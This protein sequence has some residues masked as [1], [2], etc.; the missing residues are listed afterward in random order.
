MS[1]NR[2]QTGGWAR[3][4][5]SKRFMPSFHLPL[6]NTWFASPSHEY[7]YC[8]GRRQ[9]ALGSRRHP[10]DALAQWWRGIQSLNLLKMT[11]IGS[12]QWA[13]VLKGDLRVG[14]VTPEG[15]VYY[16][17]VVS[18]CAYPHPLS[19]KLQFRRQETCGISLR[20]T[21]IGLYS[22]FPGGNRLNYDSVSRPKIPHLTARSFCWSSIP[23]RSVKIPPSFL[24]SAIYATSV[25]LYLTII[26]RTGWPMCPRRLSL[27]T[28]K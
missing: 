26:N 21:P 27:R 11:L 15:Q 17:D 16:G 13:Y 23:V 24:R 5:N 20:V 25:C 8:F 19:P 7:C 1:H 18:N 6:M 10:W 4:Q 14:T 22:A 28:S 9:H 12:P 3:Q 2:L